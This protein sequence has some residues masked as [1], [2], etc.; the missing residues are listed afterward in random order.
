MS[1]SSEPNSPNTP[2]KG[3]LDRD[4][5]VAMKPPQ[6]RPEFRMEEQIVAVHEGVYFV[7]KP[8]GWPTSG[9]NLED[10]E[11]VQYRLMQHT[12]KKIWAVHQ[13]DADTSGLNVFTHRKSSV[14][15]WQKR[16]HYPS[17]QKEYLALVHGRLDQFQKLTAPIGRRPDGTWGTWREGKR[18]L[19]HVI[20]V[21]ATPDV[22]LVRVQLRTGRT[23][24]IRV[25]LSEIG[26]PLV[27]EFWYRDAPC[28]LAERHMLHAWRTQFDAR[29]A[30]QR[31]VVR[32]PED[33]LECAQRLGVEI[34]DEIG[35][36]SVRAH[37]LFLR[38]QGDSA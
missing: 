9:R 12:R 22:S 17:A 27:G 29:D 18:A 21:C 14:H 5:R 26:H 28:L 33:W 11:C 31:V 16:L 3:R 34:P 36:E 15:Y 30:V 7:N 1:K 20:P 6:P 24:Q 13:L 37:G 23:H 38:E 10:P 32:P 8:A 4:A 25:H 2:P 35:G 19:T